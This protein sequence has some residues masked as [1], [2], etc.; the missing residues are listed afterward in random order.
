M[1]VL[2]LACLWFLFCSFV[3][4][5][6]CG[7]CGCFRFF[8]SGLPGIVYGQILDCVGS[9]LSFDTPSEDVSAQFASA[10]T[11][12]YYDLAKAKEA[13]DGKKN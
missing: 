8:L 13:T 6:V 5:F 1:A 4:V 9:M 11:N 3:F 7:F 2:S 10:K 12:L